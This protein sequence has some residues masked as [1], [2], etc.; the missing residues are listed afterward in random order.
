[1]KVFLSRIERG[2]ENMEPNCQIKKTDK[3]IQFLEDKS[4]T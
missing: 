4:L 3:K 1:M 2:D